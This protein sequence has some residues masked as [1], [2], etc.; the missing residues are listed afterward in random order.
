MIKHY[1]PP[2]FAM[3]GVTVSFLCVF[4][5][6][7]SSANIGREGW[8][9]I[10]INF[11]LYMPTFARLVWSSDFSI[12]IEIVYTNERMHHPTV[13]RAEVEDRGTVVYSLTYRSRNS[14]RWAGVHVFYVFSYQGSWMQIFAADSNSQLS[15]NPTTGYEEIWKLSDLYSLQFRKSITFSIRSFYPLTSFSCPIFSAANVLYWGQVFILVIVCW[16]TFTG[17]TKCI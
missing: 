14:A 4:V 17:R 3:A 7:H 12:L 8:V 13:S 6:S 10:C 15:V 9:F 11:F 16:G 5:F 2:S 1:R